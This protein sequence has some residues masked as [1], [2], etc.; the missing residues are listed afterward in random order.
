M[1]SIPV[2]GGNQRKL[3]GVAPRGVRG[4][5]SAP[6]GGEWPLV[7]QRGLPF[8]TMAPRA[9]LLKTEFLKLW[10]LILI[11]LLCFYIFI[12]FLSCLRREKYIDNQ[13]FTI[14]ANTNIGSIHTNIGLNSHKYRVKFTQI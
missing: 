11:N 12:L 14:F 13:M 7:G 1:F 3:G 4:A 2:K 6:G 10:F 8:Y 9:H 5:I